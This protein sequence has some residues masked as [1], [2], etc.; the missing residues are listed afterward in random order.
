MD[1]GAQISLVSQA[2]V[3]YLQLPTVD[4]SINV[5]W[6]NNQVLRLTKGIKNLSVEIQGHRFDLGPCLVA[7][8]C[9]FDVVIGAR[10][11]CDLG[12]KIDQEIRTVCMRN[13][14]NQL[15]TLFPSRYRVPS[16]LTNHVVVGFCG[17]SQ[18]TKWIRN[19]CSW[20]YLLVNTVNTVG[21]SESVDFQKAVDKA[22]SSDCPPQMRKQLTALLMEF[23]DIFEEPRGVPPSSQF[24]LKLRLKAGVSPIRTTP[25][26][27]GAPEMEELTRRVKQMLEWGWIIPSASPWASPIIFVK[28]PD[29]SFRLVLDYRKLNERTECDSSPCPVWIAFWSLSL[30]VRCF[31]KW[32]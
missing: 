12:V 21:L 17:I 1:T 9:N 6:V 14:H 11:Q 22:I 10:T 15:V 29:G 26:K 19:G 3:D 31:P 5:K 7:P 20:G 4:I 24:D 13:V 32:I 8:L 27:L 23:S 18:A 28:K 25:Y 16:A 2:M 30:E